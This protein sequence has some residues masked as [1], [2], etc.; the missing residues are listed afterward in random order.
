MELFQHGRRFGDAVAV[1]ADADF[2]IAIDQLN[3]KGIADL[4]QIPI[5]RAEERDFLIRLFDGD[6]EVHVSECW[7][8]S[9]K[10][11]GI[12]PE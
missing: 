11:V 4:P 8:K 6:A 7:K 9:V 1:A 12:V 2:I 5:G 10:V 3:V